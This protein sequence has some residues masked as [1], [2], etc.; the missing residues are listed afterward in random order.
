MHIQRI[1]LASKILLGLGTAGLALLTGCTTVTLTNLTPTSLP[2]NPSEIYTFTLRVVPRSNAIDSSSIIPHI[3]LDG[4]SFDM[5]RSSLGDGLYDFDYQLPAGRDRMAYYYLVDYTA[6]GNGMSTPGQAY[7]G[8]ANA[9]VVH[10]YV[11]SL[12]GNRGPI[13]A[14]V[15]VLGRGFTPQ[16]VIYLDGAPTRT[17]FES[18]TS[19]SFFVPALATGKNYQV[20]LGGTS[21]SSP[22]G[23]FRVDPINLSVSPSSLAL[24]SGQQQTLT[25]SVPNPAPAGGLLIDV[26]TDAPE[27][28][29]MPEV[30][31]P[32]GQTSVAVSVQGGKPGTGSLVL[33]GYGVDGQITVPLTVT[34]R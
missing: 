14:R 27:S 23:T 31:V 32:E 28:V 10:R 11:L 5:K 8:V 13:G 20:T 33:K 7:T 12:E 25:F 3:V 1:S 16:D 6:Q 17:V 34:A 22:V 15:S 19:L 24:V 26:A 9:Q 29:I 4:Q 21:S 30:V 2:E 18:S